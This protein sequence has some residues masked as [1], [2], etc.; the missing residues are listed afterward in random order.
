MKNPP[1]TLKDCDIEA[2]FHKE[3]IGEQYALSNDKT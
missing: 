3:D 2:V 1:N